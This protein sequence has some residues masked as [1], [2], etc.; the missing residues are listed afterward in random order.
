MR[1]TFIDRIASIFGYEVR[2]LVKMELNQTGREYQFDHIDFAIQQGEAV[3]DIGSGNHPFSLATHLA[4]LKAND[5][6]D[7]G[8]AVLIKDHRP[9]YA[10]NIEAMPFQDKEFDFVYCSHVL[11]HV[12]DPIAACREIIRIGKR[13]Y[14][15]TPTRASDMLY[16]FLHLHRWHV[17]NVQNTL[18]FIEYSER[19][20]Q[21]TGTRYF[22]EQQR[23]SFDNPVKQLISN[24]RDLFCNMFKWEKSF[25]V[26]LFDIHGNHRQMVEE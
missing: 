11:E 24:N 3:L 13:G 1:S 19:E 21:G 4:D 8:G 7:R 25:N 17:A 16:N 5:N 9:F 20:R 12:V 10:I 6:F 14:I 15:E 2:P 22:I 23:N 26:H 18:I